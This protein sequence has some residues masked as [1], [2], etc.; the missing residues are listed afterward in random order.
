MNFANSKT[1]HCAACFL[2]HLCI[3]GEKMFCFL[4]SFS[5]LIYEENLK[6]WTISST[7]HYCQMNLLPLFR[8]NGS[9]EPGL[10]ALGNAAKVM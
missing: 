4:V 8:L 10:P 2:F 7:G 3:I 1:A 5:L 6:E 9:L